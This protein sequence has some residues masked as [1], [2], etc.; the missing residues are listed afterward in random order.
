MKVCVTVL[1]ETNDGK[2][3]LGSSTL[4][5]APSGSVAGGIGIG[6]L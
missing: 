5:V 3:R 6:R 4:A 2:V 1:K